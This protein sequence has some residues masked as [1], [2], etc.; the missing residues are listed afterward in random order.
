MV[1]IVQKHLSTTP[2][3]KEAAYK[4]G[5]KGLGTLLIDY[6]W[7]SNDVNSQNVAVELTRKLLF[8]ATL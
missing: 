4:L 2:K 1:Q 3:F 8:D 6:L 5:A 7:K